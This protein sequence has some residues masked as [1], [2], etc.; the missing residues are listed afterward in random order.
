[1]PVSTSD[2]DTPEVTPPSPPDLQPQHTLQELLLLKEDL[3][4]ENLIEDKAAEV[5]VKAKVNVKV[6][7]R[8]SLLSHAIKLGKSNDVILSIVAVGADLEV[9]DGRGDTPLL[10]ALSRRRDCHVIHA[11]L[12]SGVSASDVIAKP[13]VLMVALK[14]SASCDVIQA[15]IEAGCDVNKKDE[16][17]RWVEFWDRLI[18]SLI[19]TDWCNSGIV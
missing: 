2:P 1:M 14:H 16:N 8:D 12:G 13:S 5:N 11:L 4:L 15:L 3:F 9:V 18:L 17:N 6:R 7:Q 19:R 10:S